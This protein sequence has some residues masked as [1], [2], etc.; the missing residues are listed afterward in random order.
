MP[1]R[2]APTV[3]LNARISPDLYD[4][5]IDR[6][7]KNGLTLTAFV[8]DALERRVKQPSDDAPASSQAGV[9]LAYHT[10]QPPYGFKWVGK[11][12]P[13]AEIVENQEEQAV[14]SFL[15]ARRDEGQSMQEIAD[16]ANAEG[17]K[18]RR[19]GVWSKQ[20][21]H[22]VMSTHDR[23]LDKDSKKES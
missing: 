19:G 6:A 16:Q 22:K 15:L 10:G 9:D 14:L 13:K 4:R 3:Q 8:R 1:R 23:N 11:G 18:T 5:A 17:H 20:T 21:V 12:T 7:Q 2:A